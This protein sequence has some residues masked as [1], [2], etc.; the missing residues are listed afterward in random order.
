M[1]IESY[2]D[3]V[4]FGGDVEKLQKIASNQSVFGYTGR[5]EWCN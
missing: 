3:V 4:R 1:K 5:V 2:L